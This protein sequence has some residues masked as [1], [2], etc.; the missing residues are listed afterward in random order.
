MHARM[1]S[2]KDLAGNY[3]Y[4]QKFRRHLPTPPRT[5]K[6]T[7]SQLSSINCDPLDIEGYF[8]A[9]AAFRLSGVAQPFWCNWPLADPHLFLT[10]ESLHHWHCE[11]YDHDVKW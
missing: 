2:M 3:G 1:C 9:C 11:F 10:P 5:T 7:L 8:N 6:T 4:G